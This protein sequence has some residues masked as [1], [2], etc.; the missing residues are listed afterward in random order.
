M[1]ID[2]AAA[3]AQKEGAAAVDDVLDA[4]VYDSACRVYGLPSQSCRRPVAGWRVT[5]C[6]IPT[7]RVTC[8]L[9]S[10]MKRCLLVTM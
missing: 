8:G 10:K 1:L 6:R 3:A 7:C 4:E 5:S 2:P 9:S